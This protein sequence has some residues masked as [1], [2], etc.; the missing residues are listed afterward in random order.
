VVRVVAQDRPV[1]ERARLTLGAVD[2]DGRGHDIRAVVAHGAPL[3]SRGE[4]R[5][6][7]A[8][9]ASGLEL[10]DHGVGTRGARRVEA[11]A[12]VHPLDVLAEAGDGLGMQDPVYERHGP[13]R[14]VS[15]DRRAKERRCRS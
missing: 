9:Q 3:A 12:A 15:R 1:L 10:G 6:A 7:A 8:A 14:M 2:H 5:A 13:E 4:P 11:L